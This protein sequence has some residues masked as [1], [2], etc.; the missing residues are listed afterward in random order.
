MIKLKKGGEKKKMK[1][2]KYYYRLKQKS[3]IAMIQA[4]YRRNMIKQAYQKGKIARKRAL[5][6]QRNKK[7]YW[8]AYN[9]GKKGLF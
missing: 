7:A 3:Q 4:K 2:K 9:R 5:I 8:K 6:R 1:L